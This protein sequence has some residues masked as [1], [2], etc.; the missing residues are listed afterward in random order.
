MNTVIY[1]NCHGGIIRAMFERHICTKGKFK[2]VHIVNYENLDKTLDSSHKYMLENC[3][4]FMY[5]PFNKQHS[6]SEYDISELKKY[7][8]PHCIILR[9]NYYR[10]KGFW[11]ESEYKPYNSYNIYR[12][13][14]DTKYFGLHN[15]FINFNGT[16]E[17]TIDKINNIYIDEDVFLKHFREEL[18]NFKKIDD[19]SDITMYEYF[20]NNYKTKNLFNDGFHPTNLF[21]YE[22]FRQIVFKLIGHELIMEDNEFIEQFN[23]IELTEWALPILPGVKKILD[24]KTSDKICVFF[25]NNKKCMSIYDYYYIRLSQTNFINYLTYSS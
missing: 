22:I 24:I 21:L 8:K 23:N 5:Q 7:L 3:D 25:G 17:E 4:V 15:S 18:D 2:I 14:P 16:K 20:I 19:N 6:Y 11:F 12:F 9:I 10:F 1:S 13:A